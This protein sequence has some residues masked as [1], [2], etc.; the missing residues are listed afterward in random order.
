MGYIWIRSLFGGSL[1]EH[2]EGSPKHTINL[3]LSYITNTSQHMYQRQRNF[4]DIHHGHHAQTSLAQVKKGVTICLALRDVTLF[5]LE[6]RTCTIKTECRG[7]PQRVHSTGYTPSDQQHTKKL[8]LLSFFLYLSFYI[9][10]TH[11]HRNHASLLLFRPAG[12]TVTRSVGHTKRNMTFILF[13][14]ILVAAPIP[15]RSFVGIP[16]V[17]DYYCAQNEE[18]IDMLYMLLYSRKIQGAIANSVR[19]RSSMDSDGGFLLRIVGFLLV[20]CH[21]THLQDQRIAGKRKTSRWIL[22]PFGVVG[23]L[24]LSFLHN[25]FRQ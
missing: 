22:I 17:P 6:S 11:A 9:V 1:T 8:L 14:F 3:S 2:T 16:V 4:G 23:N 13:C 20:P 5:S 18:G 19:G 10:S 7:S 12:Y 21:T 24:V 25:Y 15:V